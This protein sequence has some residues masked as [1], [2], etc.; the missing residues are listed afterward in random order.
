MAIAWTGAVQIEADGQVSWSIYTHKPAEDH[1]FGSPSRRGRVGHPG[2]DDGSGVRE[3]NLLIALEAC[4]MAM[5]L[6]S[7]TLTA[8]YSLLPM[9]DLRVGEIDDSKL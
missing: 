8:T 5:A 7:R 9:S 3:A 1:G 6:L 2:P 4:A